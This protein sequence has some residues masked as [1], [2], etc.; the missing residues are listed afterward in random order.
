MQIILDVVKSHVEVIGSEI[1]EVKYI[2]L[3]IVEEFTV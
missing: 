3:D 2:T 1:Y